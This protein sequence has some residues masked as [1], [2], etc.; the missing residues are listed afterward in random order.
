[1]NAS[2]TSGL[3]AFLVAE[4]RTSADQYE[5]VFSLAVAGRSS[6]VGRIG[7]AAPM[8]L[9]GALK[10]CFVA[11]AIIAP[12]D[13]AFLLINVYVGIFAWLRAFKLFSAL[14]SPS[15]Y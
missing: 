10:M 11:M 14:A 9:T 1:M 7:A 2:A 8:A 15:P 13:P 4:P 5:I 6:P 12:A 3:W